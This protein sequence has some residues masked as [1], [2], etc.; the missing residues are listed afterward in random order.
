MG[1]IAERAEKLIDDLEKLADESNEREISDDKLVIRYKRE[2]MDFEQ[3]I[4]ELVVGRIQSY[5]TT[6]NPDMPFVAAALAS[7][8]NMTI[9][10]IEETIQDLAQGG[11]HK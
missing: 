9:E 6:I 11:N 3:A 2:F 7:Y 10:R 4:I 8:T 5:K 1:K